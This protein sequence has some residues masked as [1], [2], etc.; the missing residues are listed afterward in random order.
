[1]LLYSYFIF[2]SYFGATDTANRQLVVILVEGES[3][4]VNI[5]LR[6]AL[7]IILKRMLTSS[8]RRE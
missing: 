8:S 7:L 2:F 3:T 1:M 6:V 5:I 4:A